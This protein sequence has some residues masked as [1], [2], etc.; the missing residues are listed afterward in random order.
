MINIYRKIVLFAFL[1]LSL[2]AGAQTA[3]KLQF[4]RTGTDVAST[5]VK[6]LDE[7][8]TAISGAQATLTSTHA[9]K[10][11][12]GNVTAG[13]LCP[14]VNGTSSPTIQFTFTVTGLPATFSYNTVGLDI[15][16]LNGSSAYQQNNDNRV[17]QWNV[18]VQQGAEASALS[19]FATYSDIDIAAGV[20]ATG[21]VHKV[22]SQTVASTH[23]AT[24]PLVLSLTIT[25]GTTNEGCFFGLSD[26]ILSTGE[27]VE[28]EQPVDNGPLL[29]PGAES[30]IYNIV[31]QSNSGNYM[32]EQLG[33]KVV[34]TS[35]DVTQRIFW[36]VI[37]TDVEHVYHVR[38]T[39]TGRYLASC[40]MAPS[41]QSLITTTTE[42]VP[43]YIHKTAGTAAQI[44]NCY[45]LSSTDCEGYADEGTGPRALNKDGASSNVITWTAGTA[46]VGSYWRIE[47][48]EDL[49]TPRVPQGH[50]D[51]AKS[52]QIYHVPCTA[53]GSNYVRSLTAGT[54]SYKATAQPTSAYTLYVAS[55]GEAT[56]G[57]EL[58]LDIE[59]DAALLEG[60]KAQA[61]FDW[62]FDGLFETLHE[63]PTTQTATFTVPV[64]E[65]AREGRTRMRIRLNESGEDNP[66][67][68]AIGQVLDFILNVKPEQKPTGIAQPQAVAQH[69]VQVSD[70]VITVSGDASVWQLRLYAMDGTLVARAN[71]ASLSVRSLPAGTYVLSVNGEGQ[72]AKIVLK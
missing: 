41:N 15:H 8:G 44:A 38:N 26:I 56:L 2:G 71:A 43:Y 52:A 55:K 66:D 24:D 67:Y 47:E 42:P 4:Q 1:A 14:N 17:R 29:P 51:Y 6:V 21:S 49:Y 40:N 30:R 54:L 46:N 53:T 57:S 28:P 60:V 70:R 65:T 20:G 23:N 33:N 37:P 36:E 25:K 32:A 63:L 31:W 19:A 45:W 58:E 62:D 16:A 13:I 22:W 7:N 3:V 64:P 69:G 12:G 11:T 10:G 48:T 35:Y 61:C 68:D 50:S 18:A 59:Y 39:A 9:F 27:Y 5:T 72:S 34:V